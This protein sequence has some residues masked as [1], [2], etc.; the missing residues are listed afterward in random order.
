MGV[1]TGSGE[2]GHGANGEN[3]KKLVDAR[4][5]EKKQRTAGKTRRAVGIDFFLLQH[6]ISW[7]QLFDPDRALFFDRQLIAAL[8]NDYLA[9]TAHGP[10]PR[11]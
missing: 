7:R 3:E 6:T 4:A 11:T 5:R 10:L 9:P 2:K 1:S 8:R